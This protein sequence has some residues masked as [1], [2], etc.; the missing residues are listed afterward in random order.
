ML[1]ECG[2]GYSLERG[3]AVEIMILVRL[4]PLGSVAQ[5]QIRA[6][7]TAECSKPVHKRYQ[8]NLVT[9]E[10]IRGSV[11]RRT[12]TRWQLEFLS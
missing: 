11:Y 2:S 8:L 10:I 6:F 12:I 1:L 9:Q 3:Y 5:V 4:I 7:G